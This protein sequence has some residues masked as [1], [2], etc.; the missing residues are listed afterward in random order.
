MSFFEPHELD[1]LNNLLLGRGLPAVDS[2]ETALSILYPDEYQW[3]QN[4]KIRLSD[5]DLSTLPRFGLASPTY[6]NYE[7]VVGHA[8]RRRYGSN[9]YH[10]MILNPLRA[11]LRQ[12]NSQL[13]A[14]G[15]PNEAT[16]NDAKQS[17]NTHRLDD[18]TTVA[19]MAKEGAKSEDT[20]SKAQKE[21]MS[22]EDI[23]S[24]I[25]GFLGGGKNREQR[26]EKSKNKSKKSGP[27]SQ[28]HVRAHIALKEQPKHNP[29]PANAATNVPNKKNK[30]KKNNKKKGVAVSSCSVGS[31]NPDKCCLPGIPCITPC[32]K[33]ELENDSFPCVDEN[34]DP[35]FADISKLTRCKRG[36]YNPDT[37]CFPG[38][39][40]PQC[41]S[42]CYDEENCYDTSGDL[43][44]KKIAKR[45]NNKKVLN[46]LINLTKNQGGGYQKI[47][48]PETGRW[49]SVTGNI[50]KKILKNYLSFI[51]V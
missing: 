8:V 11:Q 15:F 29:K 48:N 43:P 28:K 50:G 34:N 42:P 27:Y 14:F 12:L 30:K 25:K 10:Q 36:T 46:K 45:E 2:A 20:A 37:C 51:S 3:V 22:G 7:F 1:D 40:G 44:F 13:T 33:H 31:Y 47:N 18:R 26:R 41:L 6:N 21:V 16:V 32:Y 9:S 23:N 17:I 19:L 4:Q 38:E 49:V 39:I 24:V 35:R 5:I